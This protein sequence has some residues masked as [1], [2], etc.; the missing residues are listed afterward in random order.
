MEIDNAF[1][2][3]VVAYK[4]MTDSVYLSAIAEYIEP[5]FFDDQN[6]AKYFEIVADFHERRQKLP[7]MTEVKTYLKTDKLKQGFK[8]LVGSF[9]ELDAQIDEDELYENTERFIKQQATF[10][11]IMGAGTLFNED[12]E[13]GLAKITANFEKI[14]GMSLNT[15][16]GMEVYRDLEK[17]ITKIESVSKTISSGWKWVDENIGG[18]FHVSEPG[19]YMFAGQA[20]IGKSIFLGNVAENIA[21]QGKTVVVITLEMS[22]MLYA[23]RISS[24]ISK[25]PMGKIKENI[26]TFRQFIQ[27][28]KVECPNGKIY[29]KEFPP[30]TVSPKQIAAFLK[31]LKQSGEKIDAIVI[32]YIGLIHTS[33]G[34]NS[35]ERIKH[36]C[37]QVRAFSYKQLFNCP[38]ISACQLNRSSFSADNPGMEGISESIGIAATAD[39]IWSIFQSEEDMEM[40]LIKLGLMKNRF[41]A[42]GM[43]QAMRIDYETLTIFQADEE[44]EVMDETDMSILERLAIEE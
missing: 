33:F 44:E 25:I 4:A 5:K 16:M 30:S 18:G 35:Y 29:I 40:K 3:K 32:D 19:L 7:T 11:G 1:F 43:V 15:D 6:I 31:K 39:V 26:P 23:K 2:E 14:Y 42:R 12:P 21:S 41:G 10:H 13:A 20:N 22:E 8:E 37:E 34:S 38:V 17:L 28:K 36:I 27:K 24:K 9:K